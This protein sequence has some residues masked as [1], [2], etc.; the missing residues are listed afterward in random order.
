[1]DRQIR[2]LSAGFDNPPGADCGVLI[3]SE[4]GPDVNMLA[5]TNGPLHLTLLCYIM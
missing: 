4:S 5:P 2:R 1:V 3:I